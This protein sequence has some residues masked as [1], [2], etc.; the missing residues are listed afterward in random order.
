MAKNSTALVKDKKIIS[1]S[2]QFGT[3]KDTSL[4]IIGGFI[5]FLFGMGS[6]ATL[7]DLLSGAI[8]QTADQITQLSALSTVV[9]LVVAVVLIVKIRVISSLVVGAIAGVVLNIILRANNIGVANNMDVVKNIDNIEVV[10]KVSSTLL[11]MLK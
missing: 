7:F 11:Q 6:V 5:G 10:N 8:N 4:V 1:C 3:M 9:L 2:H